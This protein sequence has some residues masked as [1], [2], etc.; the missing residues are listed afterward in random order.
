M[1]KL[2]L[3]L[4]FFSV[5]FVLSSFC[6]SD[7]IYFGNGRSIEGKILEKD[8]ESIRIKIADG[9]EMTV[10]LSFVVKIK[11]TGPEKK[12][13][14]SMEKADS[15]GKKADEEDSVLEL[16]ETYLDIVERIM[17]EDDVPPGEAVVEDDKV[18]RQPDDL[19]GEEQ[20]KEIFM[21]ILALEEKLE[22][23]AKQK[24]P[25][26]MIEQLKYVGSKV[27][28]LDEKIMKK[29]NISREELIDI[30]IEGV[31]L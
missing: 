28:K 12:P 18:E 7:I 4:L 30:K 15:Q 6:H 27:P 13:A 5:F 1:K 19:L 23:E 25:D 26:S 20:K 3:Y 16:D 11:E 17:K 14:V 31:G 24:F 22:Q 21:E 9:G 2:A 29:Y 10:P 8:N